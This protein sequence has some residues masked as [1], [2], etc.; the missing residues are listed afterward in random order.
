MPIALEISGANVHDKWGL[1]ETLDN[2]ILRAPRGP[3]RPRHLCLDK[4][5]DYPDTEREVRRRRIQPHIRRRGEPPLLGCVR[6]KPR[7]W[8][9]ERTNSWHNQF[10]GLLVR[11]ERKASNY[12]A[13]CEL[14]CALIAYR[15]L[16]GVTFRF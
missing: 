12:R 13:L 9:V 16:H 10:R 5:Y 15:V 6:G 8:V 14:A 11:W 2:I 4:G 7:R 3:R 1:A